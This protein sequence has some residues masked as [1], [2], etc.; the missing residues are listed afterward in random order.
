MTR[1]TIEVQPDGS[2]AVEVP[3]K[4]APRRGELIARTVAF[5]G[6]ASLLVGGLLGYALGFIDGSNDKREAGHDV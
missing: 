3:P 6:G 1:R 5:V 4:P 2:S